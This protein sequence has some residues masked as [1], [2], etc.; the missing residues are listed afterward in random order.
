[1]TVEV[2]KSFPYP[3]FTR[4]LSSWALCAALISA[5][6]SPIM[7]VLCGVNWCFCRALKSMPGL[8]FRSGESILYLPMPFVG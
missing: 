8:G 2:S 7:R 5:D 1:M 6:L 3:V 4:T